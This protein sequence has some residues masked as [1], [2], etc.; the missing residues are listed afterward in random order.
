MAGKTRPKV[1]QNVVDPSE[2]VEVKKEVVDNLYCEI[3]QEFGHNI[4]LA[5]VTC[6]KCGKKGHARQD[7]RA[8]EEDIKNR[9]LPTEGEYVE[10][11]VKMEDEHVSRS[12]I[13][14]GGE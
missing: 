12:K 7:C 13:S 2:E 6:K 11:D 8:D 1:G 9:S 5:C 3:C 4:S 14:E 10:E